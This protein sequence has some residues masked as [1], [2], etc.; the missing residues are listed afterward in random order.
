MLETDDHTMATIMESVLLDVCGG[1]FLVTRRDYL[2]A[3]DGMPQHTCTH[4]RWRLSLK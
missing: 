4:L 1:L 3:E 2:N